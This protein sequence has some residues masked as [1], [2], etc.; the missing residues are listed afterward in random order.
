[1]LNKFKIFILLLCAG[2]NVVAFA[3][4]IEITHGYVRETIPGTTISAA[5]MEIKNTTNK[6]IQLLSVSSNVSQRIE[7]HEHSMSDGM[8]K[9]RQ[10]DS[11]LVP[12]NDR[13]VLQPSGFHVMIFDLHTPLKQGQELAFLFTFDEQLT[14]AVNLPVKSIKQRQS[15]Q[16]H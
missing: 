1:M 10:V 7:L 12:A 3:A 6:P 16:H 13:V 11:I 8:M 2:I 15:H 4:P 14:V 5:Y 9:M